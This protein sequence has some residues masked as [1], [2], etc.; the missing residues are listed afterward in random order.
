[1]EKENYYQIM[2]QIQA[3]YGTFVQAYKIHLCQTDF[4]SSSIDK[5]IKFLQTMN[6]V[7]EN[8]NSSASDTRSTPEDVR[9]LFDDENDKAELPNKVI[10]R[11]EFV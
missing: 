6:L 8:D 9:A 2:N 4:P 11:Y 1:M 7:K 3:N 5:F 10:Y